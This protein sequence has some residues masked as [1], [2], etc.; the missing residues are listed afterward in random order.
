MRKYDLAVI[1]GGAGGLTV[2]A[3]AAQ[4]GAKVALIEERPTLGGDCLHVGCIPSKAL[5]AAANEVYAAHRAAKTYGIRFAGVPDFQVV[6]E[7]IKEAVADI[8][9]A[10]SA[11]RFEALGVDVYS[12]KAGF[13]NDHD[14]HI[15]GSGT[16]YGKRIVI[17]TGSRPSVPAIQG[18]DHVDF[19]T[20]ETIFELEELPERLVVIGGGPAGVELAQAFARLG[21]NVTLIEASR[22]LF[23]K[24]DRDIGVMAERALAKDITVIT[25]ARAVKVRNADGNKT[26]TIEKNGEHRYISVDD[27]LFAT[28]QTPNLDGLG[29]ENAGVAVNEG[30]IVVNRCLQTSVRHIFAVGDVIGTHPYTHAAGMEGQIVVS[31]A[32]FGLKRSVCYD[33]VPWVIYTDPE[34]FHLG[35]TEKQAVEKYGKEHIK[36]YTARPNDTDR[37]ITD[38]DCNGF[39]KVLT[40]RRNHIIGAHAVGSNAGDWMQEV[41]LAK[42]H[43]LKL[44]SLSGVIH[45]YPVRAE[46]VKNA[47]DQYWRQSLFTGWIPRVL[48]YYVRRFR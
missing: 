48:T 2:A 12:G 46:I 42:R 5:I 40:D 19:H 25:G 37:F 21:S 30:H 43:G 13:G 38:R 24:E 1:G 6:K 28:G 36:V 41:V 3:G 20:N 45:P 7:R 8:Q 27:I 35:L 31:N 33:N 34:V 23:L 47:A 16:V 22:S 11:E 4:F 15:E 26:V 17:A 29:L 10:D 14:I 18:T 39:V 9:K 32:V 44:R